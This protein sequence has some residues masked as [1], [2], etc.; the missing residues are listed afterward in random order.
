MLAIIGVV[1]IQA[2]RTHK[3]L[4][5]DA[6]AP[7][8]NATADQPIDLISSADIAV[9]AAKV[10]NLPETP[11]IVNQAQSATVEQTVAPADAV[12]VAKPQTVA[13]SFASSKDIKTYVV[14]DGD[15]V[16]SIAAKFNV[17]SD[18]IMWSNN[19]NGNTVS[20]G[21]SL[22]IPP[23][24]GIVYTV[25]SSDTIDS[26]ASKYASNK[27]Q[28]IAVNDIEIS[29]LQVNSRIL[30]PNGQKPAAPV[31]V[32]AVVSAG[33]AVYGS[34]NGYDYGF[35]TWY[36]ANR[37]AQIGRPV[38]SNLGNANT[39]AVLAASYGIA[40][41]ASPQVGAVAMKHSGAPGHVAIVESV[42]AD[43]SFWISEMNSYGQRSMTDSTPTGGWGVIDWKLIPASQT[44]GYTFIY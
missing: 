43:G 35:C 25:Q 34:Y 30:V 28:L 18:S 13:T 38:P 10:T 33:T 5:Q 29:G 39:W 3:V 36:A 7:A 8:K 6:K 20:P 12:V 1:T 2:A 14:V 4:S 24:N 22:L 15:S 32:V 21:T 37:R 23:M 27:E 19:L 11:G 17:T 31:T 41:G 44:S 26:I 9:S 16:S 40:T 42:N